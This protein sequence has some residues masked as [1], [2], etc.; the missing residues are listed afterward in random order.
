MFFNVLNTALEKANMMENIYTYNFHR[1]LWQI[2]HWN[3]RP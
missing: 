2:V 3:T 1:T